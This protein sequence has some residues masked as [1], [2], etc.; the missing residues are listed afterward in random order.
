MV[1]LLALLCAPLLAPSMA[2]AVTIN[3]TAYAD[4]SLASDWAGCDGTTPNVSLA[5]NGALRTS[6]P[7]NSSTGAFSFAAQTLA[8][9][10][11]VVTIWM[12][13]HA[14][15]A[16]TYT[17]NLD[18]TSDISGLKLIRRSVVIASESATGITN[19]DL[20][21][22]D[23]ADDPDVPVSIGAGNVLTTTGTTTRLH[24]N[25]GDTY[26]PGA[27]TTAASLRVEGTF[28]GGSET[29]VV[30]N[31]GQSSCTTS[32]TTSMKPLC[33]DASGT[34]TAPALVRYTSVQA[35]VELPPYAT[36]NAVELR[37]SSGTPDYQL[38]DGLSE[39][40]TIGS[41]SV[42]TGSAAMT[43]SVPQG[44]VLI[45]GATGINALATF[46]MGGDGDVEVRGDFTGAGTLTGGRGSDLVL[47]PPGGG[48]L[49]FGST[50]GSAD[51]V[52]G[53]LHALNASSTAATVL[54]AAGGTGTIRTAEHLN[55]GAATDTLA[56]VTVDFETND[57]NLDLD[58]SFILRGMGAFLASSTASFTIGD[59]FIREASSTTF[60]PNT[61]TVTIDTAKWVTNFRYASATTFYRLA[62]TTPA[63]VVRF[64]ETDQTNVTG[65]LLV[66]GGACGTRVGLAGSDNGTTAE[67]D[68]TGVANVSFAHIKD[69]HAITARSATDSTD[70]GNNPGWTITGSCSTVTISG[71]MLQDE[72]GAVWSGCDGVT[73]NV[74]MSVNGYGK[75][76]TTCS[77]ATGAYSFSSVPDPGL[78]VVV[79]MDAPLAGPNGSTY[80]RA[81]SSVVDLTGLDVT[82]GRVRLRSE[83]GDPMTNELISLYDDSMEGNI[84][85]DASPTM[86]TATF[87]DGAEMY[88][89]AGDTYGPENDVISGSADVRGTFHFTLD[90]VSL[91][92]DNGGTSTSCSDGPGV[93]MPLCVDPAGALRTD[94]GNG[95][96]RFESAS[97]YVVQATTYPE[98]EIEPDASN[99]NISLGHAPG[100]TLTIHGALQIGESVAGVTGVVDTAT[101]SP[102][103]EI[104]GN[105]TG[106]VDSGD[107][108]V[109]ADMTL[110]GTS[111]IL[112][113]SDIEGAGTIDMTGGTIEQRVAVNEATGPAGAGNHTYN[114]V[115]YSNSS[116]ANQTIGFVGSTAGTVKVRG[117][118]TV[119]KATDT[120]MTTLSNGSV[121]ES[122]DVDGNVVV[123]S[124]GALTAA[125][126]T[127]TP[128]TIGD[129]LVNQGTFTPSGGRVTFDDASRVSSIATTT[130]ITFSNLS[131]TT[132]GKTLRLQN[133]MTTTVTGTFTADGGSCG[134]PVELESISGGS[135]WTINAGTAAVQYVTLR[136][137]TASPART[138]TSAA[139][140]GN[141]V[142]WTFSGGCGAPTTMLSH[143][144]DAATSGIAQN[145]N[146]LVDTPHFSWVN[147]ASTAAGWQR[148][149][150]VNTPVDSTV[151]ALWHLDGNGVDAGGGG[152]S[153][154]TRAAP[155]DASWDATTVKSG[156]GQSVDVD[157]DDVAQTSA[158]APALD[159]DTFTV[160]AWVRLDQLTGAVGDENVIVAKDLGADDRNFRVGVLRTGADTGVAWADIS[161]GGAGVSTPLP[162]QGTTN[163]NDGRW[164][165]V[166][167]TV[168]SAPIDPNKVQ[169]LYVDGELQASATFGG[170]VDNPATVVT[171]GGSSTPDRFLD[172][173]ID[174]VRISSA[175][176]SAAQLRGYVRTHMPHGTSLWDSDPTDAGVSFTPDCASAARCVD[177]VYAGPPLVRDGARYHV[178]GK[179]KSTT[180]IWSGWSTWD[181][182]ETDSAL[183]VNLP[184]GASES[185]GAA[186]AGTDVTATTDVEIWTNDRNGYTLSVTGPDD[187]YGMSG[188]GGATIPRWTG[189]PGAPTSWPAGTAG[190][191]GMTVLAATGGKDT[192]AWGTGSAA[193][194]FG[195]LRYVGLQSG[196]PA[197]AHRRAGWS[198]A[199]DTITTS[200]RAN[201]GSSQPAGSYSAVITYTVVAN[202]P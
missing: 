188:P 6:V 190:H 173:R 171:L 168:D 128:F 192:A 63:K 130:P 202:V 14:D 87:E 103:I 133:G 3:G 108:D 17:R 66:N 129:D 150:V 112:V 83:T 193:T 58:Q 135:T 32:S 35:T 172:G 34:F 1:A 107:L 70:G 179:L 200:Y 43:A 180:G 166:A 56:T 127:G 169:S 141:N 177:V 144:T 142:G 73:A 68:V 52:V 164:H 45:T 97:P 28:V 55:V 105:T 167:F 26:T 84:D 11:Q 30:T 101:H 119:G 86:L 155:A 117:T 20:A 198:S 194:D 163:L 79:W 23:N 151:I 183:T 90:R 33:I 51:W 59:E 8:A 132:P 159:L 122:I 15:D 191:F 137:S 98:L 102:R 189:A 36:L 157:G 109:R 165:H 115:V 156:F 27:D 64:D 18:T 148:A 25:A 78:L 175:V 53:E 160:E 24:V 75:Q 124:K 199:T 181:F 60:T 48:T 111:D 94:G 152:G 5:V 93:Q 29:L 146:I 176:R 92:L 9:A 139:D 21:L 19:A 113:V 184:S 54:A 31:G 42:G 125:A 91:T 118:M 74:S 80:S 120:H 39:T 100:G 182:F 154:G 95:L 158:H 22:W 140:L 99:A 195:A 170:N 187:T 47:R 4:G 149:Q 2:H 114:D 69:L 81:P 147:G 71:R 82:V 116:G 7:C 185:L 57:R 12:D 197:V 41:L 61:G 10:D 62:I 110:K 201:V 49:L 67:I 178:R 37:P 162:L 77:A 38:V 121:N 88:V 89:E 50:S 196:T 85:V 106:S 145:T 126:S 174:E 138:A 131:S 16:A 186:I 123:T 76:S 72:A 136:D 65:E 13:G 104:L 44:D 96:V 161:T 143:D 153:I 40:I 134:S 46:S